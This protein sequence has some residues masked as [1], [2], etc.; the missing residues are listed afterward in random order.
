MR[1]KEFSLK[2][3]KKVAI[4]ANFNPKGSYPQFGS[5]IKTVKKADPPT[6]IATVKLKKGGNIEVNKAKSAWKKMTPK[7]YIPFKKVL[8]IIAC[9]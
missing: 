7:T 2:N 3:I 6:V 5:T 1:E 9:K 8:R 4:I